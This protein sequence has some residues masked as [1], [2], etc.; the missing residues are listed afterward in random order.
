MRRIQRR[1]FEWQIQRKRRKLPLNH[2]RQQQK[3]QPR[4]RQRKRQPLKD[5]SHLARRSSGLRKAI[6][7]RAV[8]WMDTRSWT[9]C[10]PKRNCSKQHR[11]KRPPNIGHLAPDNSP[12]DSAVNG[13]ADPFCAKA[14]QLIQLALSEPNGIG[15]RTCSQLFAGPS[16]RNQQKTGSL[17][18]R[19]TPSP[20]APPAWIQESGRRLP[21]QLQASEPGRAYWSCRFRQWTSACRSIA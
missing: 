2:A 4:P 12:A 5:Q 17:K 21:S 15:P 6:G 1:E 10:E 14:S 16:M 9:G 19:F 20:A 8:A 3:P 11:P 18:S 7:R 13:R